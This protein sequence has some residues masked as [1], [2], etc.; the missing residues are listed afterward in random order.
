MKSTNYTFE[1]KHYGEVIEVSGTF[2]KGEPDT[3]DT[4]GTSDRFYI[5]EVKNDNDF[6]WEILEI[7]ILE[8]YFS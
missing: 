6:D 8:K 7:V 4:P 2:V 1:F 5:H 3:R